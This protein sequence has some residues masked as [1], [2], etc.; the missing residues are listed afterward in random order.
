MVLKSLICDLVRD[1]PYPKWEK[2]METSS[3]VAVTTRAQNKNVDQPTQS[4]CENEV[5]IEKLK[6]SQKDDT[7]L[8][9]VWD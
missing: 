9:K 6:T 8:K 2:T 7:S 5:D 4:S 1:K 3:V